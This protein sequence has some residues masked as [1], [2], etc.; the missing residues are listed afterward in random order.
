VVPA[1]IAQL[2]APF[3][4]GAPENAPNVTWSAADDW[5]PVEKVLSNVLVPQSIEPVLID[6]AIVCRAYPFAVPDP[7]SLTFEPEIVTD[8]T[9]FRIML[10]PEPTTVVDR[11]IVHADGGVSD[12]D[13]PRT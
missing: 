3:G 13:A 6:F 2:L 8:Q 9:E 12:P 7:I 4:E 1:V 10:E 11:P 5:P